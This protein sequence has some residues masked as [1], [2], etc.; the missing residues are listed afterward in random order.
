MVSPF[1]VLPPIL[2]RSAFMK[3]FTHLPTLAP[4]LGIHLHWGIEPSQDQAPLLPLMSDNA[5]LC[6]I[7]SWS[8]GSINVYF[9]V[10]GLV[11]R[12]SG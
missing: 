6:Y 9:L 7:G 12:S 4:H 8:H 1:L 11:P 2:P 10:G 5:I 3:V